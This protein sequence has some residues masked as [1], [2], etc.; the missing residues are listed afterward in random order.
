MQTD[1]HT[2][3]ATD[4][5][6]TLTPRSARQTLQWI[7]VLAARQ[8]AYRLSQQEGHWQLHIPA[9]QACQARNEIAAFEADEA[10]RGSKPPPP[11]ESVTRQTIESAHWTGFWCAYTLVILYLALGAFDAANPL[12]AAGALSRT[13]L[14]Q[15]QWWRAATALTLHSGFS[16]LLANVIFLFFIGQAVVRELGRGLGPSLILAGGICGNILAAYTAS[17]YQRSVGASTACFA[18]LGSIS[19]LQAA[20]IYRRH[21]S[22]PRIGRTIG[23]PLAAGIAL[24]GITGT[25][26][27]SDMIAHLCGFLAGMALAIPAALTP[28]STQKLSAG[29]QWA[30]LGI[31]PLALAT[32]WTLAAMHATL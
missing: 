13:E 12:H 17:P 3:T 31:C 21:L 26:P 23:L 25:S 19:L 28:A 4:Q 24:L 30:L 29:M 22:W 16:H 7:T 27:G 11:P 1:S 8:F 6:E 2:G 15:G 14:L 5:E 18:A 20:R 9:A 10:A 32:A